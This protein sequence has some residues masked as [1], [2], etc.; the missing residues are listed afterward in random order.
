MNSN[1]QK[2]TTNFVFFAHFVFHNHLLVY[3]FKGNVL[4]P[5]VWPYLTEQ[6]HAKFDTTKIS[7]S[8]VRWNP[9]D[10]CKKQEHETRS[11][12]QQKSRLGRDPWYIHRLK[13]WRGSPWP[14]SH[15]GRRG[16]RRR[17]AA[18]WDRG[19]RPRREEIRRHPR[20]NHGEW[21]EHGVGVVAG[22]WDWSSSRRCLCGRVAAAR[23]RSRL[24]GNVT[25][26]PWA[27]RRQ[28]KPFSLGP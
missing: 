18:I 19:D 16:A 24:W 6:K 23:V 8:M 9:I 7:S 20:Q 25:V 5:S 28:F 12:I 11:R 10:I 22:W 1:F 14:C 21:P 13:A 15:R 4:L 2:Y 27:S 3:P 26:G 17:C